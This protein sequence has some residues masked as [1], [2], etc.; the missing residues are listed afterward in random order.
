[1]IYHLIKIIKDHLTDLKNENDNLKAQNYKVGIENSGLKMQVGSLKRGDDMYPIDVLNENCSK[2][3]FTEEMM[4]RTL[5]EQEIRHKG[6]IE[7]LMKINNIYRAE[8]GGLNKKLEELELVKISNSSN[9]LQGIYIF[10]ELSEMSKISQSM[11]NPEKVL[12]NVH[13]PSLWNKFLMSISQLT[14]MISD[15]M[16]NDEDKLNRIKFKSM[17]NL[18]D[19][20]DYSHDLM[21]TYFIDSYKKVKNR[22]TMTQLVKVAEEISKYIKDDVK[23]LEFEDNSLFD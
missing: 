7:E 8:I 4:N 23:E 19:Y 12:R 3:E 17:T 6:E 20:I 1:M 21:K 14:E 10:K 18:I 13:F 16:G 9:E 5:K 22:E 15:A 2:N 11:Y